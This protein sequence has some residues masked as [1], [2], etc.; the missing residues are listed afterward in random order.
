MHSGCLPGGRLHDNFPLLFFFLRLRLSLVILV[1]NVRLVG[2]V[3]FDLLS[4]IY[5][6]SSLI[7]GMVDV[8]P[9]RR[10]GLGIRETWI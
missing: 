7:V 10:R 3:E 9:D 4:L 6:F 2:T 5:V 1:L 8:N